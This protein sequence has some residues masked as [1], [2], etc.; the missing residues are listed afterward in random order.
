LPAP[1]VE[2]VSMHPGVISTRLL[3]AMF[4]IGGDSPAA[5]ADRIVAVA[6]GTADNG[7]YYDEDRRA[8]PN[9]LALD[10]EAQSRLLQ[11]TAL[12]LE[13]VAKP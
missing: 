7:S 5:A 13:G 4:S 8:V 3:H 12:R 11:L 1:D 9:P 2:V 10:H 6:S